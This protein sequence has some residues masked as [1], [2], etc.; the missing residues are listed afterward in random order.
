M[1]QKIVIMLSLS[2]SGIVYGMEPLLPQK[3]I[4]D[5]GKI[6]L[7]KHRLAIKDISLIS[8]PLGLASAELY[9]AYK[10]GFVRTLARHHGQPHGVITAECRKIVPWMCEYEQL[11]QAM[12]LATMSHY[13]TDAAFNRLN[14][15]F[16]KGADPHFC[17]RK[18]GRNSLMRA[19]DH[20]DRRFTKVLLELD[21]DVHERDYDNHSARSFNFI[22]SQPLLSDTV[23][24][25]VRYVLNA[26]MHYARFPDVPFYCEE[27]AFAYADFKEFATALAID[28]MLE[29][30]G[31]PSPL[32]ANRQPLLIMLKRLSGVLK[33]AILY[34]YRNNHDKPTR[35]IRQF[36]PREVARLLLSPL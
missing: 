6:F 9:K 14:R 19:V 20:N 16:D 23:D 1:M 12:L 13:L 4:Q 7:Q 31:V 33:E 18:N 26:R 25:I 35:F 3:Q 27:K 32:P 5:A 10:I 36:T 29:D 11:N 30:K 2:A 24:S 34:F 8:L 22:Y 28:K 21:V 15:L 17:S